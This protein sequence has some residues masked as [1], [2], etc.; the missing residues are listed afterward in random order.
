MAVSCNPANPHLLATA[1]TDKTVRLWDLRMPQ[2]SRV[3][4]TPGAN[5]NLSYHP[6]GRYIAL[7]DKKE[8]VS[9]IDAEQAGLLYTIKDGSLDRQEVRI[10]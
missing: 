5:I 9:C 7:G 10:C 1:S 3:I 2:A 8:T 6:N 4:N